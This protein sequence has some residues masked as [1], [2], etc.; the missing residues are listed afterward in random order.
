VQVGCAIINQT[1]KEKNSYKLPP[2]CSIFSAEAV[3]IT[4]QSSLSKSFVICS[5]SKSVIP[6][7][8][9]NTHKQSTNWVLLDI[10]LRLYKLRKKGKTIKIVWTPS[11]CNIKGNEETDQEAKVAAEKGELLSIPIP[12]TDLS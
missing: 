12:F 3:A 11:H 9:G 7:L 6:A 10:K 2:E 1:T 8:R 4:A 5:D